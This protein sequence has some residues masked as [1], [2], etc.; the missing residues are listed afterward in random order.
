M[1]S[2]E[3]DRQEVLKQFQRVAMM[4]QNFAR[5]WFTDARNDWAPNA[6]ST[7][8]RKGSTRLLI[9]TAQTRRSII[10]IVTKI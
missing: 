4:G 9:D 7:V 2:T 1:L 6:P 5:G 8:R 10:G 3:M